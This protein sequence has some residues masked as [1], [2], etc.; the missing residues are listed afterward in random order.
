MA[1]A[2]DRLEEALQYWED[3]CYWLS[4]FARY[5]VGVKSEVVAPFVGPIKHWEEFR[6]YLLGA[7]KNSKSFD[8]DRF[9]FLMNEQGEMKGPF[10]DAFEAT[11]GSTLHTLLPSGLFSWARSS[12][13]VYRITRE[14]QMMLEQTSLEGMKFSDVKWP[15]DSFVIILDEPVPSTI[16]TKCDC[17]LVSTENLYQDHWFRCFRLFE[18]NDNSSRRTPRHIKRQVED[19]LRREDFEEV[20]KCFKINSGVTRGCSFTI[21][22]ADSSE[23]L[24]T[25][26]FKNCKSYGPAED[27]GGWER[28]IRVALGLCLYLSTLP[29]KSA[30]K[31]GWQPVVATSKPDPKAIL[32]GAE[33]CTVADSY[34]FSLEER[35]I[36]E[37][38][39]QGGGGYQ[40]SAHFRR[41]H[42]RRPPGK[43]SDPN[44]PRV[45]W[46]RPTLVRRDRLTENAL[47]GGSEH[48]L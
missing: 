46:V 29:P 27:N 25:N 16:G 22:T 31:S 45:I 33:V 11:T 32:T 37:R 36:F 3:I 15:F 41:G 44:A 21:T 42:W 38:E 35:S 19:A 2:I 4:I 23:K 47:P 6:T 8:W 28:S 13:R 1:R 7:V 5:P 17:I 48:V 24:V 26:L 14:L 10:V 39:Y 20:L 43:G 18:K 40:V 30:H 34:R 9:S 12:R